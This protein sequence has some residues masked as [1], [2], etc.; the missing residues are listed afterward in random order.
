MDQVI[1]LSERLL[2]ER[3]RLA[4]PPVISAALS[5]TVASGPIA[6]PSHSRR[7]ANAGQHHDLWGKRATTMNFIWAKQKS[8]M[9]LA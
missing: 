1:L 9:G 3:F 2:A 4:R 5:Q 7:S 8:A 6:A